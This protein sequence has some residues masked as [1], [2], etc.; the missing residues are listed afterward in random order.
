MTGRSYF[1]KII[2]ADDHA[3]VRDGL[4][5]LLQSAFPDCEVIEGTSFGDVISILKDNGSIDLIL[6][7]FTMDDMHASTGIRA[8][9][10]SAAGVPVV[11]VSAR[12]DLDAYQIAFNAGASAF[13]DKKSAH[14]KVL[15]VVTQVMAGER[16]FP[17]GV[18]RPTP[19]AGPRESVDPVDTLTPRQLQVLAFLGRGLSNKEIA[20]R[21]GIEIGTVKVYLNAI[22]RAFGVHNRTQAALMAKKGIG[23]E[24]PSV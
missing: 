3:L 4:K 7:D 12:D 5:M 10:R 24:V 20:Q 11:I 23:D 16:V 1:M 8:I 18:K 9:K 2:L 17:K 22:Y 15:D 19:G 13:V 21:I 6:V 14:E